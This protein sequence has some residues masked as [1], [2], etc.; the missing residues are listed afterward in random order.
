MKVS[1]IN[2]ENLDFTVSLIKNYEKDDVRESSI[3]LTEMEKL[4][5]FIKSDDV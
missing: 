1:L 5:L 4:F 2:Y 3:N